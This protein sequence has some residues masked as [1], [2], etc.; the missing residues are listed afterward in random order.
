VA[1][2]GAEVGVDVE[3]FVVVGTGGVGVEGEF[4][5]L[6]PVEGGA[7][8]GQFIVAVARAIL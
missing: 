5:V 7:G 8:F 3:V 6:F 1:A 4:E 2:H